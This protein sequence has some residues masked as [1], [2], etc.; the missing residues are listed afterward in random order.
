MPR[1]AKEKPVTI[2]ENKPD[3][4]GDVTSDL[5]PRPDPVA[6]FQKEFEAAVV[7][8][9]PEPKKPAARKRKPAAKK[10]PAKKKPAAKK[11]TAPAKKEKAVGDL[12]SEAA[13]AESLEKMTS[14]AF[15]YNFTVFELECRHCG[16][17]APALKVVDKTPEENNANRRIMA[18]FVEEHL[19]K[20]KEA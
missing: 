18:V 15:S 8:V 17:K 13:V 10:K 7:E 1:K 4:S 20:H 16:E 9:K 2:P 3:I 5:I 19:A 14:D 11:A 12:L 6:E